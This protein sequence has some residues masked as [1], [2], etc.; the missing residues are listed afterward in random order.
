M[1][2][3]L[4]IGQILLLT[5]VGSITLLYVFYFRIW[6]AF[7]IGSDLI[8]AAALGATLAS[9]AIPAPFQLAARDVVGRSPLPEALAA[10]DARVA[11]LEAL[12]STLLRGALERLGFEPE[13]EVEPPPSG[14]GPFVS[15]VRPSVETLVALVLRG[16]AFVCAGFLLVT[17][18]AT[19]ASTTTA[20]RL[21]ALTERIEALEQ[22]RGDDPFP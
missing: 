10:A 15:R 9:I 4:S 6:L 18:L 12:P 13:P 22:G 8:F 20:R 16:C 7:A 14:P 17:A 19:R 5:G 11:E 2:A 21:H 3:D 1:T